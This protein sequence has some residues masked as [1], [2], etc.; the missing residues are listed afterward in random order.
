MRW[1]AAVAVVATWVGAQDARVWSVRLPDEWEP[2]HAVSSDLNGDG[3]PDLVVAAHAGDY[4]RQLRVHFGRPDGTGYASEPSAKLDLPTDVVIGAIAD[5]HADPGS[6]IVLGAA[7]R[8]VAWRTS[9]DGS[10]AFAPIVEAELLWHAPNPRR[11]RWWKQGVVDLDDDGLDDLLVPTP[12]G[13]LP[14]VQTRDEGGAR[15]EARP[16]LEL[17]DQEV[18][19]PDEAQLEARSSERE[20][21]VGVEFSNIAPELIRGPLLEIETSMPVPWLAD[22]DG[23]GDLDVMA[24]A[25]EELQVWLQEPARHFAPAPRWRLEVPVV[26]DIKRSVDVAYTA[27]VLDID[28]DSRADCLFVAGDYRTDDVR[29]QLLLYVRGDEQP[30]LFGEKGRPRQLLVLGGFAA[31]V[32]LTD[33]DGDGTTDLVIGSVRPDLVGAIGAEMSERL[34]VEVYVY[35]GGPRGFSRRPD[36]SFP[37][38]VATDDFDAVATVYARFIGD[39]NGDGV[40]ELLHRTGPDRVV[41]RRLRGRGSSLELTSRPVWELGLHEKTRLEVITEPVPQLIA[42]EPSQVLHVTFR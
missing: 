11:V 14:V 24:L 3:H 9:Q 16:A 34:E 33:V 6:E 15:F 17:M 10:S 18:A 27:R 38:V 13:Y 5:V 36:I 39:V 4:R 41:L 37:L 26:E 19:T 42:V 25:P 35:R 31:G 29:T 40:S 32:D 22:W 30:P 1:F 23:D 2:F 21:R 20:T 12:Q 7:R 28:R 8:L